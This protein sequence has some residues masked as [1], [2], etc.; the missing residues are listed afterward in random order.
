M[1]KSELLSVQT[2]IQNYFLQRLMQQ[3]K[4][5]Y[6]TVCS[7]KDTFR[8]YLRYLEDVHGISAT[9]ASINHFDLQYLQSF[10]KYLEEK[11]KNKPVTI[12]NRTAAI[13]S[14]MQYAAEIAPEY[15]AIS[16]RALMLPAQKYETPVMS[17]V[18]KDEF[19]TLVKTCDTSTFIGARDKLMLMLM[20]NT[21]VRVSELLGI[22][23]SDIQNA[24]SISHASVIIHGK[25]RKQREVPLWKSTIK[26]IHRYLKE[27]PIEYNGYLF[28][29]KN[30]DELTRSGV[31]TRINKLVSQAIV[32][33]PGLKEKT[34]TP[35]TFRHSVAM[36]LLMS[37]IDISTI[38]IWLGHSSIE[39]T[40]KYMVADMELK[41]KAMEKAGSAGNSSYKYKPSADIMNFLNSL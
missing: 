6:Q 7:Y 35:H 20:Y 14:F 26:Y 9:K 36:N 29:N 25:G 1:M 30:G 8:V 10:C 17:F 27:Y 2:L 22:R 38:A 11:R 15:S 40:H 34:I 4:V 39:T 24:D 3:R 19:N 32:L 31:R 13:K 12:N 28:I 33:A 16:K 5:S 23:V 21:G 18:T 41:R 37:G